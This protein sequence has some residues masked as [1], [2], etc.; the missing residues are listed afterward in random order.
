[1]THGRVQLRRTQ[2]LQ[3]QQRRGRQTAAPV[4]KNKGRAA[5]RARTDLII[6]DGEHADAPPAFSFSVLAPLNPDICLASMLPRAR[7]ECRD[8]TAPVQTADVSC[9]NTTARVRRRNAD[10]RTRQM[11]LRSLGDKPQRAMCAVNTFFFFGL[12][13]AALWA[14]LKHTT[15]KNKPKSCPVYY[16]LYF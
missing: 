15:A 12:S 16:R 2:L 1:M 11:C 10:L 14:L 3:S 13:E 7:N 8:S 5:A 6:G 9:S 4:L